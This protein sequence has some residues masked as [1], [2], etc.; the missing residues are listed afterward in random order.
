MLCLGG[1]PPRLDRVQ[2]T[3]P[4]VLC[5][6]GVNH[7]EFCDRFVELAVIAHIARQCDRIARPRMRA[8]QGTAAQSSVERRL[9]LE[10]SSDIGEPFI[11]EA[12]NVKIP[13]R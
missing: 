3:T 6:V 4:I 5:L 13:S 7:R 2:K 10:A 1:N 11:L 12:A 8:C 9:C